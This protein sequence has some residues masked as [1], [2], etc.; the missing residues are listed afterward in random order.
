MARGV[1]DLFTEAQ[2]TLCSLATTWDSTV[3]IAAN[4]EGTIDVICPNLSTT[5]V[6][7]S[8]AEFYCA[9]EVCSGWEG[10][11][12]A[13]KSLEL[14][15]GRLAVVIFVENLDIMVMLLNA[16]VLLWLVRVGKL[17]VLVILDSDFVAVLVGGDLLFRFRCATVSDA[18]SQCISLPCGTLTHDDCVSLG[19]ARTQSSARPGTKVRE[20]RVK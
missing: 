16:V 13:T 1:G 6:G 7:G 12:N 8:L 15:I 11:R 2:G 14:L 18:S 4:R 19:A 9:E 10:S 5:V 17:G 3:A 20:T